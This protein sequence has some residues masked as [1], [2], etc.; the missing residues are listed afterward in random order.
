MWLRHNK[1]LV[2]LKELYQCSGNTEYYFSQTLNRGTITIMHFSALCS[3]YTTTRTHEHDK[4][5]VVYLAVDS[6][7]LPVLV[8]QFWT[9]VNCHVAQVA[10][11]RVHLSH[12]F[13]HLIFTSIICDPRFE[14]C[15]QWFKQKLSWTFSAVWNMSHFLPAF[16]KLYFWVFRCNA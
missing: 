13:F 1:L 2:K 6:V 8:L 16:L 9:H 12:V 7:D 5:A 4:D 14:Y 3:N 15:W 11:H 10:Y